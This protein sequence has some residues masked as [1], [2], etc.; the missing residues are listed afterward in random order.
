MRLSVSELT[1][2]R[3]EF[4]ED[5][6]RYI[7]A[8]FDG[9][10]VWREKLTDFGCD[11][12]AE[13]L[14]DVG[15]SVSS[16]NWA[17]GFTG[18]DGR[19][20]RESIDDGIEAI[21][22][23]AN[24]SAECLVVY[25]GPRGGH[26]HKHARRL[27]LSALRE[28]AAVADDFGVVLAIEPMH[29]GCAHDWTFLNSLHESIELIHDAGFNASTKIVYDIYHLGLQ[30]IDF[31]ELEQLAPY[32]GLVQLGNGH[33]DPRGEQNRCRLFEGRAPLHDII[34]TL[35]RGGYDGFYELE[36]TGEE[37]EFSDKRQ[38]LVES[39][40]ECDALAGMSS[41]QANRS[42]PRT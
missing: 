33:T 34:A 31:D 6:F 8:G 3:W 22:Q 36:L 35:S 17:G 2:L 11:A 19:S 39:R 24:L 15:L 38:L 7:E 14:R 4:E 40:L 9:I 41:K 25:T 5:V 23:A 42:L 29:P 26:T 37:I 21:R 32:I 10:G 30:P 16:L 13:L 27:V 18:S 12:G 1:T 28:L 20:H